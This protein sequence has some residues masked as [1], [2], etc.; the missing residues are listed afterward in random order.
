M[1]DPKQRQT[2]QN[3]KKKKKKKKRSSGVKN[4][5]SMREGRVYIMNVMTVNSP[6]SLS[7][8]HPLSRFLP[9]QIPLKLPTN[10]STDKTHQ[11]IHLL[12]SSIEL[13]KYIVVI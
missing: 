8:S 1:V 13:W 2:P 9:A 5:N 10:L 6:L 11:C 12:S 7:L 3:S 4:V